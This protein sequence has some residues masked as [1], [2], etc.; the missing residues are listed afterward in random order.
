MEIT[1]EQQ[2]DIDTRVAEFKEK[3]EALVKE[4]QVDFVTYPQKIQIGQGVYA[5]T[6]TIQIVDKKYLPI[7][8][9]LNEEMRP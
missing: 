8:S 6:C 9:P 7:P 5:D 1:E 3:Y 4:T 2:V